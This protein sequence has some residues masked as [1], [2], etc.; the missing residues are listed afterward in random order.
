MFALTIKNLAAHKRRLVSTA[1][2]VL[3]GVAFM[4]GTFVLTDT[5]NRTL[6][7]QVDRWA[8]RVAGRTAVPAAVG[9]DDER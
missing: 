8:A 5:L 4:S 3:L 1:F 9:E 2:A 6:H 7:P